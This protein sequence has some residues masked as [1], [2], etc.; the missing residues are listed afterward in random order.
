MISL[1]LHFKKLQ[2]VRK[3]KSA[4]LHKQRGAFPWWKCLDYRKVIA[5]KRG[6]YSCLVLIIGEYSQHSSPFAN[7]FAKKKTSI[8]AGLSLVKYIFLEGAMD[9]SIL[10]LWLCHYYRGIFSHCKQYSKIFQKEKCPAECKALS[11]EPIKK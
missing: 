7:F 3:R 8:A 11:L 1:Y 5:L 9:K 6:V 4:L 2:V 10:P